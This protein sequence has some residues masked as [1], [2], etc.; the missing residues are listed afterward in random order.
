MMTGVSIII[1]AYNAESGLEKSVCSVLAQTYRDIEVWI[2]NDGSC[3]RTGE[4]ANR[5]ARQDSRVHVI[6]QQNGGCYQARLNAL[7]KI[8]TPYF[9]FVDADDLIEPSM[10]EK[11][12]SLM[13]ANNFDVV[14]CGYDVNGVK[15][16]WLGP[17]QALNCRDEV[18]KRYVSPALVAGLLGGTFVW[19]K[20]YRNKYDFGTFDPTDRDTTFEDMIYNLQFFLSVERMGFIDEPLYHYIITEGSSVRNYSDKTLHDFGECIRIRKAFIPQYGFENARLLEWQWRLRNVRNCV[21]SAFRSR[22][23]ITKRISLAYKTAK[24]LLK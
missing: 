7:K 16:E 10:Y 9:G 11:M 3:D 13:E 2:V 5:L 6:H 8:K 19:N 15:Q 20:L 24:L 21:V 12:L 1:P 14:Q 4:V 17:Q 23:P 22:Q 18:L